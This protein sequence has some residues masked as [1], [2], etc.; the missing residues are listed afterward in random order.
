MRAGRLVDRLSELRA[1]G[2]PQPRRPEQL[3]QRL[4]VSGSLPRVLTPVSWIS[5]FCNGGFGGS[6]PKVIPRS[7]DPSQAET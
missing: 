3:A 5:D 1:R 7:G 4:R 6:P 2:L